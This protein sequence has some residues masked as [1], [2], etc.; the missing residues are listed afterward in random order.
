[1]SR[2]DGSYSNMFVHYYHVP[3]GYKYGC[4]STIY[5]GNVTCIKDL[6]LDP[7]LTSVM[8]KFFYNFADYY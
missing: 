8:A 7:T 2:F 3:K 4:S 1:M 5:G 6:S